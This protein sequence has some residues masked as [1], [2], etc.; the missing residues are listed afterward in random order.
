MNVVREL[1]RQAVAVWRR[2]RLRGPAYPPERIAVV[3]R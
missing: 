3:D 2:E 1:T